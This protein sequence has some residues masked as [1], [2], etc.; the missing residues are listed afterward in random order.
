[1]K[2]EK[3]ILVRCPKGQRM[4]IPRPRLPL[5]ADPMRKFFDE[6]PIEAY[7]D[8]PVIIKWLANGTIEKVAPK[9][10]KKEG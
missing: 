3:T 1:M 8:H 2:K 6:K 5:V 9:S 10:K 4:P 7:A